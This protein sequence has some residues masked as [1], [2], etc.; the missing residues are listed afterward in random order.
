[1]RGPGE[2]LSGDADALR[3]QYCAC[4]GVLERFEVSEVRQLPA[5]ARRGTG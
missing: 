5:E 2:A 3:A 4:R 1:M